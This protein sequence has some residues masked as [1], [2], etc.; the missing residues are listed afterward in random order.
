M[1]IFNRLFLD[2]EQ[3]FG[4]CIGGLKQKKW[5]IFIELKQNASKIDHTL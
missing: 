3:K 2:I 1:K 5:Q 4:Y